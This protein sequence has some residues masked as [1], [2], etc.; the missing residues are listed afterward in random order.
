[1][2]RTLFVRS[3][4]HADVL[5]SSFSVHRAGVGTVQQRHHAAPAAAAPSAASAA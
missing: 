3:G 4:R 2:C 5:R 1:M